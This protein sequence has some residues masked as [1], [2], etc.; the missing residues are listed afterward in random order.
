MS[1]N[2]TKSPISVVHYFQDLEDPR[3]ERTRLHRLIDIVVIALCAVICGAETWVEVEKFGKAKLPWLRRLLPLSNGIPSHDTFGRV[4]ALLAPEK[5]QECFLAWVAAVHKATDGRLVAIDGKTLR[6]SFDTATGKS[7]LHLVSAWAVAN[8]VSLGQV[9]VAEKSNEITA[10]PR[11]LDLLDL[12][13]AIVTIDAMGCQ[14]DIAE[15]IRAAGGDYV[16]AVKGNQDH[17]EDDIMASFGAGLDNDWKDIDVSIFTTK[18]KGH[19]RVE[20]RQYLAIPVP[21]TLRHREAWKDLTSLC[22]VVRERTQGDVTEGPEAFYYISSL[23]P[24]A[25]KLAGAIR[26]HWGI[27]NALHYI[28]DVSFAED[29]SRIRKDHA[30]ANMG[31]LR[32]IATSLLKRAEKVKGGTHAK[33]MQAGW[34]ETILE[35]ILAGF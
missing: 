28:L 3:M 29:Q 2:G 12:H 9:A 18:N 20:E 30:P 6:H 13:G 32:R 5:F 33:R 16:L 23:K 31:L 21:K 35:E 19:G 11:L 8:H 22:M 26:G 14:K 4:F 15:Q 27:E 10:I 17:L 1:R 25:K 24:D 7:A 34:D